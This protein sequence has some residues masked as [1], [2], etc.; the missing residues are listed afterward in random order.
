MVKVGVVQDGLMGLACQCGDLVKQ[1][2][3]GGEC[4]NIVSSANACLVLAGEMCTLMEIS[5]VGIM[6]RKIYIN[7]LKYEK[8]G[9]LDAMIADGRI[10]PKYT[11]IVK[12]GSKFD[13][14]FIPPT[15][16]KKFLVSN[17]GNQQE[18]EETGRMLHEVIERF[19]AERGWLGK[20]SNA[21]LR[22][23]L[24]SEVG[25]VC[26]ELEWID[27]SKDLTKEITSAA[28]REIA[29]VS[30]YLFHIIRLNSMKEN[31]GNDRKVRKVE[32]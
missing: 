23:S 1:M 14:A 19:S 5:L 26:D 30:I 16:E 6:F 17:N 8:S 22:V 11:A 31:D 2:A 13:D 15:M 32:K 27:P 9:C 12:T 28:A 3:S 25:E 21:L 18:M 4:S 10:I 7:S 24:F 29:D 20:Y